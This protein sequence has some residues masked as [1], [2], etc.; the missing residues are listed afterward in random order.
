M[1]FLLGVG[2]KEK[3]IGQ[4]ERGCSNCAG[5]RSHGSGT[6]ELG[7]PLFHFL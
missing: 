6:E 1:L 7:Y 3:P 5:H 2:R 4:V